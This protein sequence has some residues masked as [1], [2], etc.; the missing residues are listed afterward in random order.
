MNHE[1]VP[2]D[3]RPDRWLSLGTLHPIRS[4]APFIAV[5]VL[6]AALSALSFT[7]IYSERYQSETTTLFEP[8][9]VTRLSNQDTRALGSPVPTTPFKV[10]GQTFDGLV[11]SDSILRDTVKDLK[12]DVEAPMVLDGP[13]WKDWYKQAK[14]FLSDYGS[15]A[16]SYLQFGRIV[17][18]DR[19]GRAVQDLRKNTKVVSEDSYV[20]TLRTIAKTPEQAAKSAD[21]MASKLI[22]V[23]NFE[24]KRSALRR[25]DELRRLSN[26]KFDDIAQLEIKLRDL[27]ESAKAASIDTEIEQATTRKSQLQLQLIDAQAS[28]SQEDSRTAGY[29][30]RLRAGQEESRAAG[31]A[32]RLKGRIANPLTSGDDGT[33]GSSTGRLSADDYSHLT[34]ERLAAENR[35]MGLRARTD[36]LQKE[37]VP[38]EARLQELN[39]VRTE[40]DLISAQLQ[41]AKRDLVALSDALQESAIKASNLQTQLRIQSPAQAPQAPVSPIKIYHVGLAAGVALALGMGMAVLLSYFNIHLLMV[42]EKWRVPILNGPLPQRAIVWT[43]AG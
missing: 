36:A 31:Y 23:I 10:I 40:Y 39:K 28:L 34:S 24:D 13:W 25:G 19:T 42:G 7:Y 2:P 20:F 35:A 41:A 30:D 22:G 29:A 21:E 18:Q 9:E 6:S 32:D 14:Q 37:L 27:L 1:P 11:K 26:G 8:A 12:L 33:A 3:P 38:L 16:W 43:D 15:D 17:Q 4:H 5:F